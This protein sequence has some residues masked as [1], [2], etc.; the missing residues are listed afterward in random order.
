M[1]I[2]GKEAGGVVHAKAAACGDVLVRQ[3]ELADEPHHFLHIEG[4]A[5][6][7]HLKHEIL[8]MSMPF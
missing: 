1:R 5:P 6:A 3:A 7:P 8:L 2:Q 4:A